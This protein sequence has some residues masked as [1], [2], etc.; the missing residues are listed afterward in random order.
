MTHKTGLILVTGLAVMLCLC[1]RS[2]AA[3]GLADRIRSLDPP[4][5]AGSFD[6]PLRLSSV[7]DGNRVT[8]EVLAIVSYPL[9]TIRATLDRPA[10]W[11]AVLILHPNVKSCGYARDGTRLQI[12]MGRKDDPANS[13]THAMEFRF[14]LVGNS[15]A[16]LS[17]VLQ[18]DGGPLGT[19]NYRLEFAAVAADGARSYV[20][21][22]YAY[23]YGAAA[24][25]ATA[26]YLQTL[27]RG[28][29]GFTVT[30]TAEN[31]EPEYVDGVR[32]IL[33]RNTMRYYLAIDTCL[34]SAHEPGTPARQ[35]RRYEAW[36][37]A[38]QRYPLQ[39]HELSRE[40]YLQSK[41]A[42]RPF[43]L[44]DSTDNY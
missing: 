7:Q 3:T 21:L 9:A 26:T 34:A 41:Q 30:G 39:L 14:Q 40:D 44:S 29:V 5:D 33:E 2:L 36:H 16:G 42:E 17:V 27:G 37:D 19:S 35:Q 43:I 22:S 24:R 18:A 28:K 10:A 8:G 6:I 32:G 23:E 25:L 4:I 15:A 11:C 20:R 12:E 38:T 1:G 31:G 13:G